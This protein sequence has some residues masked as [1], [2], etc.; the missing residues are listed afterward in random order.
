M[1]MLMSCVGKKVALLVLRRV[2]LVCGAKPNVPFVRLAKIVFKKVR[3]EKNKKHRVGNECRLTRC[4]VSI[5]SVCFCSLVKMV[6]FFLVF[7]R[8][9]DVCSVVLPLALTVCKQANGPLFTKL[10]LRR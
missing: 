6:Y 10:L 9:F 5:W 1:L 3:W 7:S 8:L 2:G 4:P